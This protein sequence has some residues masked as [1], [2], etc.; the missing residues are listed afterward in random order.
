M[1]TTDYILSWI[2]PNINVFSGIKRQQFISRLRTHWREQGNL[3][4]E[5]N[6][7]MWLKQMIDMSYELVLA[8]LSKKIQKEIIG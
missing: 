8:K 4:A 3:E 1:I 5:M 7:C 6:C 2:K